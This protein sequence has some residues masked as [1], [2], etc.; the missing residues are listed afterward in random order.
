M[1]QGPV[2]GRLLAEQITT[3]DQPPGLRGF[4]PLR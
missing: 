2:T 4:N 1:K 3:G